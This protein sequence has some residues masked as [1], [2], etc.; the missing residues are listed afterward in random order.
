MSSFI[1]G[2]DVSSNQG[3]I[4]WTSVVQSDISFCFARAAL[5]AQSVDS[6]F[7]ANWRGA[8]NAGLIRGA[9]H[10]FWPSADSSQQADHF[11][12]VVGALGP[13]D[14]APALDLEEA[15]PR[16]DRQHDVWTD[17][18]AAQRLPMVQDWLNRVEQA[19][20]MRPIVYTRQNFIQNLVGEGI[21]ALAGYP[22]WVSHYTHAPQ[23]YYPALWKS[24][25]FWQYSD[26]GQVDGVTGAVDLDRFNGTIAELRVLAKTPS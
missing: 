14:L 10:F 19:L 11:V 13:G 22:L 18:P 6:S 1:E 7:A 21:Q 20:G 24:W 26:H 8:S 25:T 2:I 4:D 23:P 9:Y 16:D 5:G 17:I 12:S 15:Y 3:A